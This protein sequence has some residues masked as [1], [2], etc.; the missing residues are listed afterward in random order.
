MPDLADTLTTDAVARQLGVRASTLR[1]WEAAG[2]IPR[3]CGQTL[4][5]HRRWPAAVVAQLAARMAGQD[6]EAPAAS[7]GGQVYNR[8]PA[9]DHAEINRHRAEL[10]EILAALEEFLAQCRGA[11]RHDANT[12]NIETP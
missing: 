3:A 12:P 7:G 11:A 1:R 10:L 9:P 4:G 8:Q 6:Q 2:L 5:G